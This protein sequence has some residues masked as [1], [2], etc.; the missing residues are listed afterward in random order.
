[1]LY[2][3]FGKKKFCESWIECQRRVLLY[4]DVVYKSYTSREEAMQAWAL[5]PP[6]WKIPERSATL[7]TCSNITGHEDNKCMQFSCSAFV[8]CFILECLIKELFVIVMGN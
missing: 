1:M 2:S 5:Y 7:C 8:I 6:T 3:W 4:K